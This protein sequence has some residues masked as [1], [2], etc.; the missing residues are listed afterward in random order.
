V[1]SSIPS[2]GRKLKQQN[3]PNKQTNK[4]K[5]H[6]RIPTQILI[7]SDCKPSYGPQGVI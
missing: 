1:W 2:K 5:P 6:T 4:Q 7:E 3:K